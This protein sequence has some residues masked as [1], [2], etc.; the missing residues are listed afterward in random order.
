MVLVLVAVLLVVILPLCLWA[1]RAST[2][3]REVMANPAQHLRRVDIEAFRNLIDPAEENFLRSRLPAVDFRRV[4]RA[5]LGAAVEY[6]S[7]ASQNAAILL[8]LAEPARRNPDPVVA[9]SA[10]KLVEEATKLR[11]YAFR[12]MPRLYFAMLFPGRAASP[13]RVAESYEQ[14]TQ[15]VISLEPQFPIRNASAAL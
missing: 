8:R 1:A 15:R 10:E 13:L 6:I 12:A 4:Q 2:H 11:L 3:S 7:A 9:Q 5:R 14:M